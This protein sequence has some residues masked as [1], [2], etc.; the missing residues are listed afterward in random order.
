M[1]TAL[2]NYENTDRFNILGVLIIILHHLHPLVKVIYTNNTQTAPLWLS[3]TSKS[4]TGNVQFNIQWANDITAIFQ[5]TI[6]FI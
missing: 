4:K 2:I 1:L 3:A 6:I 5:Y